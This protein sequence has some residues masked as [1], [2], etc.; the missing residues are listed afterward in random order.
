MT[1]RSAAAEAPAQAA[2][3][4]GSA[5][6]TVRPGV[7]LVRFKPSA[8]LTALGEAVTLARYNAQ[9]TGAIPA[10][11]VTIVSVPAGS[12]R[13]TAAALAADPAVDYAEPDYQ[14]W[15]IQ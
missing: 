15:L 10:I 14:L 5:A 6:Q 7:V 12:E 13:V 1:R 2:P 3:A 8:A 4:P 11:G 9:A